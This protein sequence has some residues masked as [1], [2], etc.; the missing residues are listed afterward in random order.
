VL[1]SLGGGSQ[2]QP[3]RP[4]RWSRPTCVRYAGL[5]HNFAPAPTFAT[6]TRAVAPSYWPLR[7]SRCTGQWERFSCYF[8]WYRR[9]A[10]DTQCDSNRQSSRGL[11]PSLPAL[12]L[13]QR[14]SPEFSVCSIPSSAAGRI[15]ENLTRTIHAVVDHE[16]CQ[17]ALSRQSHGRLC[18]CASKRLF[19]FH[20]IV[21]GSGESWLEERRT[22]L[23]R[24]RYEPGSHP[25]R[26]C[27]KES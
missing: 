16:L 1:V 2:G 18:T 23:R 11:H 22:G 14:S 17:C 13:V 21:G 24:E 15:P 8:R 19:W 7:D 5:N 20:P 26:L 9:C 3:P 6:V 27:A 25:G 12:G 10:R 4:L